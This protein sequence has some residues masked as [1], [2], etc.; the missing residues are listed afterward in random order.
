W[1]PTRIPGGSS[2]GSGAAVAAGMGY[3]SIG[4][5]TGGSIRIPAACC[6]IVG[7]KPTF[8]RVSRH[9]LVPLASSLDH[10]G[11]LT[12]T[13]EDAALV[14]AAIAGK[15][16][17]DPGSADAPVEPWAEGLERGVAGVR[18]GVLEATLADADREVAKAVRRAIARLAEAGAEVRPVSLELLQDA[19][20]AVVVILSAEAAAVHRERLREHADWFGAD[21]R[22]RIERGTRVLAMDY[23]DALELRERFRREVA[24]AFAGVDVLVSPMLPV[25]A[26]PVGAATVP[27][28]GAPVELLRA[29][30]AN[31]REWNALG[32]PA[33]TVPCG[34][35]A[36]GLPVGIQIV[37]RP[38]DEATVL[39]V[40]RAHE[41]AMPAP[42]RPPAL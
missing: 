2:G 17:R 32:V 11:P 12:R 29:T 22:E 1:D 21:V 5:D 31:T 38:F 39:R 35:T 27:I 6:G 19:R 16:P 28:N 10:A 30:T 20:A 37:G 26:P 15:D 13:V 42:V 24:R 33:I 3:A 8:G 34:V 4:T 25:G 9:G 41:R 40:A 18:V 7:L 23:V 36:E 14:L